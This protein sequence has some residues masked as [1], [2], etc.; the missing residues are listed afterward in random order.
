[1]KHLRLLFSLLLPFL[2]F[3]VGLAQPTVEEI[4]TNPP[5][6]AKPRGYWLWGHG[7]FDYTRMKEELQEFKDKGLGGVDI[8][9]MGIADPYEVIPAGNPFL[10]ERMLDGIEFA[11]REAKKLDFPLGLSVSNGWNAGGEWTKPDEMIMRLLFWQDT[12]RGPR[13]LTEV[14]FPKIPTTFQKPYGEFQLFPQ[15]A[16]DGFPEYYQDVI[17]TAVPIA[18]DSVVSDTARILTFDTQQLDGNQIN[19]QLPAGD[20]VLMRAVVTPLGQKMWMRSDNSPGFI[21]DHYSKKATKH[22]FEHVIG[23]LEERLGNLANSALKRLYLCSFEA[24]DYVI[25]SPELAEEFEQQHGYDLSPFVPIFSGVNVL[26]EEVSQRFLQDYRSTVSEMFVNNHY[27]Q[28]RQISHDHGL[29]L[30]SES[31]GPGP[32]LHYVPTEDLKAL[33]AVDIMRGEFWNKESEYFDEHGNDL[34]Q[35]VRNI[36]SA[37]H[38]YGHRV[39]EMESFTSHRKHWQETPLEL[40]KLADRAFC[41]GM[42]R[43]VYHTMPHS[44]KEAGYPGWSYQ[45]GTHI[46]PKITW[47]EYSEPFH[48]YLARTSALLQRGQFVADVAYYYGEKIPNFA[49]GSK[50]IRKTLG[51]GYDYDDLNKEVLLQ[52]SVTSDGR[53]QLPSGM[54][55]HLLVLPEDSVMSTEVLRKIEELVKSGATVL[56]AP[57]TTVP[58]LHN[59]REREDQLQQLTAQ[60]W[61]KKI[62]KKQRK[63]HGTGTLY[64]G[65]A[66]RDILTERGVEPDF[67]YQSATEATLDYIHRQTD[68]EEIYFIRNPDSRQVSTIIDF[69]VTNKIPFL[70][71]PLNG[72]ITPVAMYTT[73]NGRT[74]VPLSLQPLEST[75]IVFRSEAEPHDY[76]MTIEKDGQSI[77]S[78]SDFSGIQVSF[79]ENQ[80]LT[81]SANEPGRYML[82]LSSGDRKSLDYDP[83]I[84]S[85]EIGGSWD[86]HFPHG[87][88]FKPVQKFDSLLDWTTHPDPELSIFSGTATYHTSFIVESN[89]LAENTE[90]SLDLGKVGEVARVYLNGQE[91]GTT[92]FSPHRFSLE[93][94]L[95]EGE[96]F[97]SVDVTNTWLNQLI[98]EA[99]KPLEEQRTQSNVGSPDGKREWSSYPS[100]PSGL[101]GPVT[102][103]ARQN[104]VLTQ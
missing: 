87:W 50:Y 61:G 36:A 8:F 51:S 83:E 31:G 97:L 49:S 16:E 63:T 94:L 93:G 11:A 58:G 21:M 72:R 102:I 64:T 41:E 42:N 3:Q 38:I 29:L 100:Q 54:T 39:V 45:A 4:F 23:R 68:Q 86:V 89:L 101:L 26:N 60:L 90:V 18:P 20:W 46:S 25:W 7:N 56:G 55:Y 17:L 30:A 85:Q 14:G 34:L 84:T 33:G 35:V 9:D 47:W 98:G 69:R 19:L 44:P 12:I 73:Q 78:A 104:H 82:V 32:P 1:M 80:N 91:V 15:Y 6:D 74:Q 75:F 77:Y 62:K 66:E 10:G 28:A 24:E 65:Y 96:N 95:R 59:Y 27:R 81:F 5:N 99:G 79:D 43:V 57:P 88:G 22:H 53:L 103:R 48:S 37:A 71:N 40:K 76:V 2:L 52:S 67:R 70:F 13:K 92:V